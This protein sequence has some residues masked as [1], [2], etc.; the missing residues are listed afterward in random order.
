MHFLSLHGIRTIFECHL[1]LNS[2]VEVISGPD[3]H[4]LGVFVSEIEDIDVVDLN[5]RIAGNQTSSF[6]RG[7]TVDLKQ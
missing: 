6:G 5:N 3:D 7:A 1:P 4:V 2:H